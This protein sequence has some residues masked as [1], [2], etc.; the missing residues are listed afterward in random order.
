MNVQFLCTDEE[1]RAAVL[2]S[3]LNGIDYLEVLDRDATEESLRQR[4]LIVRTLHPV[5]PPLT[6]DQLRI[7][8]GVRVT[9]IRI[10]WAMMLAEVA[11]ADPAVVP[12]VQKSAIATHFA[13]ETE[14][15]QVFLVFTAAEGDYSRYT[16]ELVDPSDP[17]QPAAGF[18]PRSAAVAFS[19]KVECPSDFDCKVAQICPP[20]TPDEPRL[21]YLAKDYASFRRVMLDRLSATAPGWR[22]RSPADLGI[23]I[24]ELLAY[25]GDRLSYFQDA[26]ATEAYLGTARRRVSSPFSRPP[27]VMSISRWIQEASNQNTVSVK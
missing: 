14:P 23:A 11:G 19:F 4:L 18:D 1:R 22:E 27:T 24:V 25:V 17:S 16:L 21:S 9:P 12:L 7:L 13:A 20:D 5:A 10:D 8:G 6:A 2:A 15:D 26:V 3:A